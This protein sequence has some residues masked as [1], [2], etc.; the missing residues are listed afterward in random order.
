MHAYVDGG[1]ARAC[2]CGMYVHTYRLEE[3]KVRTAEDYLIYLFAGFL[4]RLIVVHTGLVC[5]S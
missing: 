3:S 2:V 4:V 5:F 1:G